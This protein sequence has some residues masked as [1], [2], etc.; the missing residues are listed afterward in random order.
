LLAEVNVVEEI[1]SK[2]WTI[3]AGTYEIPFT[4]HMLMIAVAS[5]LLMTARRWR[6]ESCS[7]TPGPD[8]NRLSFHPGRHGKTLPERPNRPLYQYPVDAVLFILTMNL[9]GM[10]PIAQLVFVYRF[11]ISAHRRPMCG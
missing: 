4:N 5:L 1:V 9:L 6:A 10:M 11:K 2:R 8:R 7:G 3:H